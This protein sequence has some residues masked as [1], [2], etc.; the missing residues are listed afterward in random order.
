MKKMVCL[1]F[2]ILLLT[3][4]AGAGPLIWRSAKTIPGG[5]AIF[6]MNLSYCEI[7]R[8]WSWPNEEW[9]DLSDANKTTV[10]GAHFMFGYAPIPKL[11]LLAH[12]PLLRKEKDT[13][14]SFGLQD[15][16]AKVR[17]NFIGEKAKP[18]ITGVVAVRI[19]TASEDANPGL[20]DRTLDIGAGLL[21]FQQFSNILVH[22]RTGYFYNGKNDADIDVGDEVELFFK[23][24]YVF[25]KKVKVFLGFSLVETLKAKNDAGTSIDNTQKRLFTLTP[26]LVATPAPGLTVRPKFIYPL[27]MLSQGGTNFPWKIGFDVWYVVEF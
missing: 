6:Q 14:S 1:I 9:S 17:Y 18:Y 19:P 3:N 4:I 20:D 21:Y 16:W 10:I 5:S 8:S 23:P 25:N 22:L 2:T 12:I 15:L 24:E 7:A 26:G 13:L 11:E 27:E